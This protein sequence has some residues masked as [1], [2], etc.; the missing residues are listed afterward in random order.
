[1]PTLVLTDSTIDTI[2]LTIIMSAAILRLIYL[3]LKY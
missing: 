2:H 1:M 3:G